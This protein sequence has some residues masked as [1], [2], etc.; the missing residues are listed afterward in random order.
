MVSAL[1]IHGVPIECINEAAV[2]YSVPASLIISVLSVEGGEVGMA[3]PNSNGTYDYGPMQI[4]TIW[5]N[6]IRPYGFT[7][8][9][10]QYDPCVNVKVGTWILATNI[11][12]SP[13]LWNGVGGYHSYTPM[14][15]QKYQSKVWRVYD[16]LSRYL[17]NPQPVA[18][19]N[20]VL[21]LKPASY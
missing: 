4:N 1:V 10:L 5:L 11:A 20:A 7:R 9:Q 8:E 18:S 19:A 14:L 15:N 16:L 21:P 17:S 6:R 3:S 13:N 2:T 12:D